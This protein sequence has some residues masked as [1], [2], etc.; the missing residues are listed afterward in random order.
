MFETDGVAV[1]G[2]VGPDDPSRSWVDLRDDTQSSVSYG[3]SSLTVLI[4]GAVLGVLVW[5]I[6][7]PRRRR[8]VGR[9]PG[10]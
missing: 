5:F 8:R 7:T 1:T 2:M 4:V 3:P 10:T 6:V 9:R